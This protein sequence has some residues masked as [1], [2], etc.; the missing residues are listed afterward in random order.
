MSSF[1]KFTKKLGDF[2]DKAADG[3]KDLAE[4]QRTNSRLKNANLSKENYLKNTEKL[5]MKP[6]SKATIRARLLMN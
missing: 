2:V 6:Q 4:M 1:D 5:S 3:A